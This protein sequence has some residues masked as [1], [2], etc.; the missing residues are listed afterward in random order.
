MPTIFRN[1]NS[2]MQRRISQLQTFNFKIEHISVE[3]KEIKMVDYL[4]RYPVE[5]SKIDI[6][7]QTEA[8]VFPNITSVESGGNELGFHSNAKKIETES[9]TEILGFPFINY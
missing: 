6:G 1:E 8:L 4:S 7:T 3:S 2:Y 9:Q 5:I